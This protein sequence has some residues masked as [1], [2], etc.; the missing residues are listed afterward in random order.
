MKDAWKEKWFRFLIFFILWVIVGGVL[1]F[2][3]NVKLF[4][5]H[6][7]WWPLWPPY[8]IWKEGYS[9]KQ[10]IEFG[11]T[12]AIWLGIGIALFR[13]VNSLV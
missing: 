6:F 9:L 3:I 2:V 11:A 13:K 4:G 8:W 12:F 10:L 1:M 7:Y 5:F